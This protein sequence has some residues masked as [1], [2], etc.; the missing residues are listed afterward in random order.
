M[1]LSKIH[2]IIM[3]LANT[4]D[5]TRSTFSFQLSCI[6]QCIEFIHRCLICLF[7]HTKKTA[8]Y[9]HSQSVTLRISSSYSA[10]HL[11][12]LIIR[13]VMTHQALQTVKSQGNITSF[14]HTHFYCKILIF[15][16]IY[17]S[18]TVTF[19]LF[20]KSLCPTKP[21]CW[22][23]LWAVIIMSFLF[24]TVIILTCQ[25]SIQKIWSTHPLL[26][27]HPSCIFCFAPCHFFFPL[28]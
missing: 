4:C 12:V 26:S 13:S 22:H 14:C 15:N 6:A 16:S 24:C 5:L 20:R 3:F 25:F 9:I 18:Y 11:P 10:P 8:R 17:S 21:S 27:S 1:C 2:H 7:T 23:H 28:M 19:P